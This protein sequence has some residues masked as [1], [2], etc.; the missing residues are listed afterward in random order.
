MG[1]FVLSN[2][3]RIMNNFIHANNGFDT[4]DVYYT[5]ADSLYF[6]N[7][8]WDNLE[9]AGLFGKNLLQGKS[10]CK[11]GGIFYGL[12]IA[13]KIN[14]CLTITKYGVKD[15]QKT[16]KEFTN[17]CDNLDRNE[18]F[19]MFDGDKL[20]AKVPLSWKKSFSMRV[21]SPHKMKKCIDCKKMF[22]VMDVI[23]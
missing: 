10:D 8:D 13:P 18:Y 16:F 17:V 5:D 23:N 12:F 1:A 20:Q 9:K 7:K 3:K 22:Y 4:N 14:F 2:S 11:D 15:E 6:E 19:K 21:L